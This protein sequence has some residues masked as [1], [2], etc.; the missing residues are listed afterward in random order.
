MQE[1]NIDFH[2]RGWSTPEGTSLTARRGSATFQLSASIAAVRGTT[3]GTHLEDQIEAWLPHKWIQ[4]P[5]VADPAELVYT[6]CLPTLEKLAPKHHLTD[7]SLESFLK[8]PT[9]HLQLEATGDGDG[10]A[11]IGQ[12]NCT[13]APNF[14]LAPIP[15][16]ELPDPC[17][18]LPRF[19]ADSVFIAPVDVLKPLDSTQGRVR[20]R[21]GRTMWFKPRL[22]LRE[23]DFEREL[24]LLTRVKK[25]GLISRLRVPELYGIVVSDNEGETTM[26]MLMT[27]IASPVQGSHLESPFFHGKP[28]LHAKWEEQVSSTVHE[29]HAHD[30]VWGDVNP[31]NVA[32]DENLDAWVI[33][34]GGMNN[35]QFLDNANRETKEGDWQGIKRL[36]GEWLPRQAG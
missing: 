6:Y 1:P 11:V 2:S 4:P 7:L 30:I 8:A 19:R 26:G 3:F 33:D 29:L 5:C 14:A 15:T 16:A 31:M 18:S 9:W 28:A 21:D 22:D 10:I 24:I 27:Y 13:Y 32:I 35:V 23:P 20:A 25:A 17:T 12:D 34:F 36:F